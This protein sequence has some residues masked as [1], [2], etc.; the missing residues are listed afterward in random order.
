M[1]VAGFLARIDLYTGWHLLVLGLG[2][3][4]TMQTPRRKALI[5][6]VVCALLLAGLATL[7]TL[8]GHALTRYRFF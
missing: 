2:L 5:A 8:F 4:G 7:P 6:V 3:A 1:A